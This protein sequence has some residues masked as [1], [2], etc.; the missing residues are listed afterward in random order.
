MLFLSNNNFKRTLTLKLL[1]KKNLKTNWSWS[2][3]N[4]DLFLEISPMHHHNNYHTKNYIALNE[5]QSVFSKLLPMFCPINIQW[6]V[7]QKTAHIEFPLEN[8]IKALVNSKGRIDNRRFFQLQTDIYRIK[9]I[10]R[11]RVLQIVFLKFKS[12]V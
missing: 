8:S 6:T 7:D 3:T 4:S 2:Y 12:T 10:F 11:S 9:C 1:Q 5:C